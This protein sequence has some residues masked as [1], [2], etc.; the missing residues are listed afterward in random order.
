MFLSLAPDTYTITV[1]ESG[2]QTTSLAGETVFADQ[3]QQV[4]ITAPRALAVIA[5]TQTS[6]AALVKSGVGGDLYNVTPEQQQASAALG[7]GGNLNNAYSAISAVPG[8]YIPTGGMGWNQSV[9]IHG[10][11]PFTTGFEY[12]GIP[13]NRA[14][15]QYNTST[16][17]N[18]GLQELQVYTGG[19]PVSVS[20]S[21]ISG[22]I[23]EVIKTGTYPGFATLGG[24]LG[25]EGFYHEAELEA[26]GSTPDRNF[27]YYVGISGYDQAARILNQQDGASLFAPGGIF[28]FDAY[29]NINQFA[30]SGDYG[31][32]VT[33]QCANQNGLLAGSVPATSYYFGCLMQDSGLGNQ[34]NYVTDREDVVNLHLGIPRR[35]GQRD[36][37]QV[38]WSDSALQTFVDDSPNGGGPGLPLEVLTASGAALSPFNYPNYSDAIDYNVPFGTPVNNTSGLA[39]T[40]YQYYYQPDS[41]QDRSFMSQL[42]S[43]A[44][45]LF[46]NDVGVAKLQWTHPFG[47]NAYFRVYGYTMFSDWT[48][49]DPNAAYEYDL[50]PFVP[51]SPNYDLITHTAGG[52]IAFADQV[53]DHNLIQLT[54]NLITATTSRWNNTGFI[55]GATGS[56]FIC[57]AVPTLV[58]AASS[59]VGLISY[60]G[61]AFTC[62]DPTTGAAEPCIPGGTWGNNETACGGGHANNAYRNYTCGDP[63]IVGAALAGGAE[64]SSMWNGNASASWNTVQPQFYNANLSEEFRPNDRL[65]IDLAVRYD[66]Y[67]YLLP[68]TNNIQN[69][70]YAQ[71]IANYAC[72]NPSTSI[73]LLT[74]LPPGTAPPP[75]PVL[76][77]VCPAGYVHPNGVG[78]NPLFT[79]NSPSNYDINYWEARG[80]ATYTSDPDT[81]WR[82]S[83]GRYA[84]PPLTAAVQYVNASGNNRSQWANFMLFGFLSPF[85]P[86]PGETSAQYDG[87]FEHHFRGSDWSIKISPFYTTSS[88]WEQQY[89][90]GAGYVTQI[91]VGQFRSYGAEFSIQAGDFARNGLS[92]LFSFTY[93]NA[94][95]KY[96]SLLS[97][98]AVDELNLAIEAY[99]CYI[100]SY[101]AANTAKC[102]HDIPN[103]ALAGG[104]APCYTSGVATACVG[105]NPHTV[106]NPY[107]TAAV[108]P[109]MDPNGWYP[110]P[111]ATGSGLYFGPGYN[112]ATGFASPYT[113]ALIL[114]WRMNRL[115][116]TPSL[117]FE[118]GTKYGSPMDVVGVDPVACSG[119]FNQGFTGT[120]TTNSP[121]NCDYT[122]YAGGSVSPWGYL[123][124]PNPQ[125]GTFASY[126]AY[127]EPSIIVGNIQAT[128]DVSPRIRLTLTAASLW[129]TCFGGSKEPWAT[130]APPG[131]YICGYGANSINYVGGPNGGGAYVGASPYASTNGVTPQPWESQSYLPG[132]TNGAG[133]YLPFNLYLQ[134]QIHL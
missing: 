122:T 105:A 88:N 64:Y 76:E 26:G 38:L 24:G 60:H 12:D 74:P 123:Y 134:A 29:N 40:P 84:E 4:T 86:I 115:A 55:D 99:N 68:N 100:G 97:P 30:A 79:D 125:T 92:G 104:A 90:I 124:V 59:P 6:A 57:G 62:Y 101:Y 36:D 112:D 81:V 14:F 70:F 75:S 39:P 33:A 116:I 5:H 85:H 132:G 41:P 58:C 51:L 114:N 7:G 78:S 31:Y 52:E 15:D 110:D 121:Y 37:I 44:N 77:A 106:T 20:S 42:P 87:S 50:G 120:N 93:T 16:E 43:N 133:G 73:P 103:L 69:A 98:S 27:S 129:H 63:A 94:A 111:A 102:A 21:G 46:H 109:Y 17:S 9:V 71:Q 131:Q 72:V 54:A 45:G 108:Q 23:N 3:T 56:P 67:N 61:G 126:G 107:Y 96:Q 91:P 95:V 82:I 48:E 2:Y 130:A 13:V 80:A 35:D 10:N 113:A 25:T 119:H 32:G 19:G 49:D 118:A 66:N 117:Q 28:A 128:Y 1:S 127:T 34:G 11:N 18:L 89:F 83:A 8:L 22:F 53:N 47:D 65:L